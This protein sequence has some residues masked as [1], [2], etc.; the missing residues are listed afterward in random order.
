M[1]ARHSRYNSLFNFFRVDCI[2]I[3]RNCEF[4]QK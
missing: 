1:R 4:L 2:W 3:T